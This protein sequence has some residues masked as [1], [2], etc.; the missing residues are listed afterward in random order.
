MDVTISIHNKCHPYLLPRCHYRLRGCHMPMGFLRADIIWFQW[1]SALPVAW[2]P[3]M[4]WP[5]ASA[6]RPSLL[7]SAT[8]T[9]SW[10]FCKGEAGQLT[11]HSTRQGSPSLMSVQHRK[12]IA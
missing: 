12:G 4:T 5:T 7:C 10:M 8:V 11:L 9:R 2:V 6:W 1:E 3:T